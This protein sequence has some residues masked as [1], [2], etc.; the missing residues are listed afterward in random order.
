MVRTITTAK[1]TKYYESESEE[2]NAPITKRGRYDEEDDY[3]DEEP[4]PQVGGKV[5][6]KDDSD[7]SFTDAGEI[8]DDADSDFGS[9]KKRSPAKKKKTPAKKKGGK[10]SA[11]KSAK[12][13]PK[14]APASKKS[15]KKSPAKGKSPANARTLASVRK[16]ARKSYTYDSESEEEEE[17]SESE[18]ESEYEEVA[19]VRGKKGAKGKKAPA[20]KA[21]VK[22]APKHPPVGEMIVTA[23]KRLR[24]NPRKGSSMAAIKGFMA[25]EWGVNI[26]AL[27]PKMK[28]YVLDAVADGDLIQRKGKGMSGRFTVPGMKAPKRKTKSASGL[29]KKWD[30]DEVEYEPQKTKREEDK[31][32][33]EIEL[34]ERRQEIKSEQV[35]KELEK[36]SRPK[37]AAP[38]RKTEW[39]VEMVTKMKVVGDET[40]YRV[41]WVGSKVQTWEPEENMGGAQ[42][43]IDNFLIEE[44]TKLREK[45]QHWKQQYEHGEYEV[46]RIIEVKFKKGGARE[47]MV[48]WKG[49][50]PEEDTWEPEENLNCEEL[51]EKFMQEYEKRLEISEKEL[52]VAPKRIQRLTYSSGSSRRAASGISYAGMDED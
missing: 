32:K 33:A 49:C 14:K 3:S 37:K 15:P 29:G 51:I 34:E 48:R 2:E 27:A 38:P 41:K 26:Q 35:R 12:K 13:S 22:K 42:D 5:I 46:A 10:K 40:F 39:E 6:Y 47:F 20:K 28:K 7:G 1:R 21:P 31:E 52:R 16:Q 18:Y 24:E 9:K 8:D 36:A 43:S 17:Q 19:P 4:L 30:E 45:E 25:E 44:K 11:K 50:P 23:I